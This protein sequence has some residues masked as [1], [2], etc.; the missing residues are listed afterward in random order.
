MLTANVF[1][2]KYQQDHHSFRDC[3]TLQSNIIDLIE[4]Q[5]ESLLLKTMKL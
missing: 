1:Y 5:I 4:K 3:E 2:A